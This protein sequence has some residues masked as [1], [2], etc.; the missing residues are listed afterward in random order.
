MVGV[1]VPVHGVAQPIE[2]GVRATEQKPGA[3]VAWVLVRERVRG[4]KGPLGHV[5][6]AIDPV[7]YRPQGARNRLSPRIP[8]AE[9]EPPVVDPQRRIG[10]LR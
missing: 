10:L 7:A 9:L 4:A 1:H 5:R 2:L 8:G 3:R 6:A